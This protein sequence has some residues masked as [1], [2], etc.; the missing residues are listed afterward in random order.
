MSGLRLAGPAAVVA[1]ALFA[2]CG[3][4]VVVD[5]PSTTGGSGGT[6]GVVFTGTTTTVGPTT[7]VTG[8][9][10]SVSSG[11][12]VTTFAS[13][14]VGGFGGSSPCGSDPNQDCFQ[15]CTD[16]HPDA[17][18]QFVEIIVKYCAC[19]DPMKKCFGPCSMEGTCADPLSLG[20]ACTDCLNAEL[21]NNDPCGPMAQNTCVATPT[22]APIFDC[23]QTC[24]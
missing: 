20:P 1:V 14:G 23:F 9:S 8:V 5:T 2:A 13:S 18:A 16:Q 11:G 22:C 6:G 10:V 4:K 7:G 12:P 19:G 17:Y 3:G 15:C 21:T 24:P